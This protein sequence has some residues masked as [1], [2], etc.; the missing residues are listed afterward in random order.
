MKISD[1]EQYKTLPT[2]LC[3]TDTYER[4]SGAKK[5]FV[6][7]TQ[8]VLLGRLQQFQKMNQRKYRRET[9]NPLLQLFSLVS[10][11]AI[12]SMTHNLLVLQLALAWVLAMVCTLSRDT[13]QRVL[14]I[15]LTVSILQL[16]LLW[17]SY[18]FGGN[19]YFWSI[20]YKLFLTVT[21]IQLVSMR[22]HWHDALAS[23]RWIHVPTLFV[24]IMHITLKYIWILGTRAICLLEAL[25]L[26]MVK[27]GMEA[28]GGIGGM[29]LIRST[30]DMDV[31]HQAMICRGGGVDNAFLRPPF[32]ISGN[33]IAALTIIVLLVYVEMYG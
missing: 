17:P 5:S 16:V 20:P 2:W 3:D 14:L 29:L 11:I 25:Q 24:F 22:I 28:L 23:L 13:I 9:I 6:E 27:G 15:S 1:K 12:V 7:K 30:L 26:R 4:A 31:L 21:E 10:F 8:A 19:S 18:W 32:R 33:D